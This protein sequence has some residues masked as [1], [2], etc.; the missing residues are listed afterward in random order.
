MTKKSVAF[1]ILVLLLC[2]SNCRKL[3]IVFEVGMLVQT[4]EKKQAEL[5]LI[6]GILEEV[7]GFFG[8]YFETQE[9]EYSLVI[10]KEYSHCQFQDSDGFF[11]FSPEKFTKTYH[12][13]GDLVILF[14][15]ERLQ[16]HIIANGAP[17]SLDENQNALIG[18][19]IL[20]EQNFHFT[21]DQFFYRQNCIKTIIHEI[22]HIIAFHPQFT[23]RLNSLTQQSPYQNLKRIFF[24]TRGKFTSKLI[25]GAHWNPAYLPQDLMNPFE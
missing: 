13:Q 4:L 17:C 23:Q 14:A 8:N 11:F 9:K 16:N 19:I 2:A 6:L 24:Q 7:E 1:Q 20:N 25:D 12:Y 3:N 18:R 22:L 10:P 5:Q 15:L 21:K